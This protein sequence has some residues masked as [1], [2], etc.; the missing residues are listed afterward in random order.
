[1]CRSTEGRVAEILCFTPYDSLYWIW[2]CLLISRWVFVAPF[3]LMFSLG[4]NDTQVHFM[5]CST[6]IP[7][8]QVCAYNYARCFSS[9]IS[10]FNLSWIYFHLTLYGYSRLFKIHVVAPA[11]RLCMLCAYFGD[12]EWGSYVVFIFR[13]WRVW[14]WLIGMILLCYLSYAILLFAHL[15]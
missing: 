7:I 4:E 13:R 9:S 14:W 1:M 6:F 8:R 3:S 15:S 2:H 10:I 12:E 11:G 5:L